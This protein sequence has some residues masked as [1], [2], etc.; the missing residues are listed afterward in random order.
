VINS[1]LLYHLSYSGMSPKPRRGT[2][3]G[4]ASL[5]GSRASDFRVP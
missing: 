5:F 2:E 3:R 4:Q 1:H